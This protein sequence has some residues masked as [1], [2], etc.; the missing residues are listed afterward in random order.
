MVT[1]I[2]KAISDMD[3][4]SFSTKMLTISVKRGRCKWYA[5]LADGEPPSQEVGSFER[6]FQNFLKVLNVALIFQCVLI[7]TRLLQ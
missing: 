3:K 1:V 2:K 5:Q 7:K 6:Y 4:S